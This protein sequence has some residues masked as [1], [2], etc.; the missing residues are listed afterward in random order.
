MGAAS[1]C[2]WQP[3]RVPTGLICRP[4]LGSLCFCCAILA[5]LRVKTSNVQQT[6]ERSMTDARAAHRRG[7]L[8]GG[9]VVQGTRGGS[10]LARPLPC[11]AA[12]PITSRW[13]RALLPPLDSLPSLLS[14]P[15]G[16]HPAH[17]RGRAGATP[18]PAAPAARRRVGSC[19]RLLP[20]GAAPSL[21]GA[22]RMG[23]LAE[24]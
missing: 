17:D 12:L 16:S 21:C 13:L 19:C 18:L 11:S 6:A 1:R 8:H 10:R 24:G 22:G 20:A 2:P 3:E 4:G 15:P 14:L 23:W 5:Y 7:L 9:R